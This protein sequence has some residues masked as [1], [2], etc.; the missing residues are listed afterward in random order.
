MALDTDNFGIKLHFP[1][2]WVVVIRTTK[3]AVMAI[4]AYAGFLDGELTSIFKK[5]KFFLI[6]LKL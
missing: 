6:V 1:L 2:P 4:N 5:S 3:L